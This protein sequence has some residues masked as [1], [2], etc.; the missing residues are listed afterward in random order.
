MAKTINV[1]R[2]SFLGKKDFTLDEYVAEWGSWMIQIM[3]LINGDTDQ[4]AKLLDFKN[5]VKE[6]A[7]KSFEEIYK[8]QI[9]QEIDEVIKLYKE[10]V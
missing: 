3:P 7:E 6:L 10:V 5:W 9:N 2:G 1:D 4:A 8:K